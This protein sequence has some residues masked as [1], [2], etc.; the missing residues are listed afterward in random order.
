MKPAWLSLVTSALFATTALADAPY[1]GT[2]YGGKPVEV[3]GTIQAEA[4]DVSPKAANDVSFH[5]NGEPRQSEVRTSP[6][7]IGL[8]KFGNGHVSVDGKAEDPKQAY[9]GWTHEGEW[10]KYSIH[11]KEAGTYKIGAKVAAADTGTKISFGFGPEL[12]SGPVEVPTTAGRQPGVE[13][14]H[15]WEQLDDL[16]E[17]KLQA[18]DAVM[19]VK[20]EKGAGINMDWFSL[21]KK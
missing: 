13:V 5:Y 14:Y 3:P 18:G 8:A 4:Y 17:V 9:V 15:V 7:S 20:I 11:V 2:P 6:D 12:T 16:A 19:T 10:L 1:T 21:V